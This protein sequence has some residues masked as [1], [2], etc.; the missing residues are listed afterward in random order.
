ML[1]EREQ[2]KHDFGFRLNQFGEWSMPAS[3]WIARNERR[4]IKKYEVNLPDFVTEIPPEIDHPLSEALRSC[5]SIDREIK[6][7]NT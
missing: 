1:N 7:G 2:L 5:L 4:I 6:H 3:D